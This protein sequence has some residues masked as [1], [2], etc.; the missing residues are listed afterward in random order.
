MYPPLFPKIYLVIRHFV[1][2]HRHSPHH[3]SWSDAECDSLCTRIDVDLESRLAAAYFASDS[4]VRLVGRRE[5]ELLRWLGA[6][7]AQGIKV[8]A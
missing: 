4:P 6:V 7:R 5:G 8:S 2:K 3:A 1:E